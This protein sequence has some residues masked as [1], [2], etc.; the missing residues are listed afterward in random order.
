MMGGFRLQMAHELSCGVLYALQSDQRSS[1]VSITIDDSH[2]GIQDNT[3][4]HGQS[5]CDDIEIDQTDQLGDDGDMDDEDDADESDEERTADPNYFV[6]TYENEPDPNDIFGLKWGKDHYFKYLPRLKR[7]P[8]ME[9][10]CP[11]ERESIRKVVK[12]MEPTIRVIQFSTCFPVNSEPSK[13]VGDISLSHGDESDVKLTASVCTSK[14]NKIIVWPEIIT[15]LIA[16]K[17]N[18]SHLNDVSEDEFEEV[19]SSDS[20][21][22]FE[23]FPDDYHECC[24]SDELD[25]G[26]IHQP[27][28]SGSSVVEAIDGDDDDVDD[29]NS[30]HDDDHHH[31]VDGIGNGDIDDTENR[32]TLDDEYLGTLP[33]EC[34][35]DS[36]TKALR[37]LKV[38]NACES[39]QKYNVIEQYKAMQSLLN[40]PED[41]Y[42]Y[43]R[44]VDNGSAATEW[45]VVFLHPSKYHIKMSEDL[46]VELKEFCASVYDYEHSETAIRRRVATVPRH[47]RSRRTST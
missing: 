22:Y 9:E 19:K 33:Q 37:R 44:K 16:I 36:Y 13:G 8:Y 26:D 31:E 25:C 5:D 28:S 23:R 7:M 39:N 14:I 17:F 45:K 10:Q 20:D 21:E 18:V 12:E 46:Y 3:A 47:F 42:S 24:K 4:K 2:S 27:V 15:A 40:P 1:C 43:Y 30:N 11:F 29:N 32:F 41:A 34:E 35:D 38:S 6:P